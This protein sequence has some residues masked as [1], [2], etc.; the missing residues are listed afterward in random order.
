MKNEQ[1]EL[2]Q[3]ESQIKHTN[4]LSKSQN[5][6]IIVEPNNKKVALKEENSEKI[7]EQEKK[8]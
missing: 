6:P 5:W 1:L 3:E 7:E 8:L 4:S 2:K